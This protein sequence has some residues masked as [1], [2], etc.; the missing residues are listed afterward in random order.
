MKKIDKNYGDA[1]VPIPAKYGVVYTPHALADFV[2]RLLI[3]C[4]EL[5]NIRLLKIIDPACGEGSLLNAISL[6]L[7]EARLIGIDVDKT[8]EK[9]L[10]NFAYSEIADFIFPRDSHLKYSSDYWRTKYPRVDAI[11]ANPPW[12]SNRI[13]EKNALHASGFSLANGQYDSYELFMELGISVLRENGLYAFILPDSLF[14]PEKAMLRKWLLENTELKIVARLGEKIFPEVFRATTVIIGRKAKPKSNSNTICYRLDTISRDAF[15]HNRLDLYTNFLKAKHSVPQKRFL[16]NPLFNIDVDMTM[17]DFAITQT[18]ARGK[19]KIGDLFSFGRG[20]EISKRGFVLA[21]NKCD[22][23]QG[24]RNPEKMGKTFT[25]KAC[26]ATQPL[27]HKAIMQIVK[28][29]Y[30]NG[31]SKMW[32]GESVDRYCLSLPRFIM[33]GVNG[34]DYKSPDLFANAKILVRKTGLGIYASI[35]TTNTLTNQT[36]YI[37]KLRGTASHDELYYYLAFIN[38]RVLYFY[39][40]KMFGAAEWKS[41]PYLTKQVI[42]TLPI[43]KYNSKSIHDRNIMSI[44]KQ[45]SASYQREL[46]LKLELLIS[47]RYGISKDQ[48][49]VIKRSMAELPELSSISDMRF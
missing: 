8:V 25:C 28:E 1:H 10:A 12:S 17:A 41:H 47:R 30:T 38:S 4:S 6:Y 20:V 23:V 31:Y 43:P 22:C 24:I 13:Y 32:V 48:M 39:Y 11:I 7:P 9:S 29:Q 27:D 49:D 46:D 26:H 14:A 40:Q 33:C 15:I 18:M 37:L 45:L 19:L 16:G 21:C 42:F 36:V 34:I 35:D 5:Y 44:S 3:K 2:S